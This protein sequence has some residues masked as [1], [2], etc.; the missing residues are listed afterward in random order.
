MGGEGY[1]KSGSR[2]W[3][4]TR[5]ILQSRCTLV[6][7]VVAGRVFERRSYRSF[8]RERTDPIDRSRPGTTYRTAFRESTAALLL[9]LLSVHGHSVT[10]NDS[11]SPS[12]H[13]TSPDPLQS[14][15]RHRARGCRAMTAVPLA[16]M[17]LVMKD[18]TETE[19]FPFGLIYCLPSTRARLIHPQTPP[20]KSEERCCAPGEF[21][22]G[23]SANG[24]R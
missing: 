19:A 20:W 11:R 5:R 24:G 22:V 16:T 17:V 10:S 15:R 1:L 23:A 18:K 9:L 12:D 13:L 2:P 14:L 4:C 3:F 21:L 8:V 6:K 7:A